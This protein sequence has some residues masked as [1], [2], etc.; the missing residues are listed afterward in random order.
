MKT[1][2]SKQIIWLRSLL[3]FP[4]LAGLL[5]SFSSRE[6]VLLPQGSETTI[7]NL[8]EGA[9]VAQLAEYNTLAKKYNAMPKDQMIIKLMEVNRLEYLYRIMSLDQRRAAEPYPVLPPT[10]RAPKVPRTPEAPKVKGELSKIPPPPVSPKV[11]KAPKAPKAKNPLNH[12]LMMSE[13]GANFFYEGKKISA[14]KA[15]SLIKKN[16]K[17]NISSNTNNGESTVNMSKK[18]FKSK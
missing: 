18:G 3:V 13:K 10:P 4:L 1:N 5:F 11:P 15:I 2:S 14:S 9:T 8:Q 12:I 6:Q 17:L 16:P 7:Q